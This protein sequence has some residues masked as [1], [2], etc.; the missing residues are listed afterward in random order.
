M[1]LETG[2]AV[3]EKKEEEADGEEEAYQ[4]K[5]EEAILCDDEGNVYADNTEKYPVRKFCYLLKCVAVYLAWAL[6]IVSNVFHIY[7]VATFLGPRIECYTCTKTKTIV[8]WF[9]W[10]TSWCLWLTTASFLAWQG[11][12]FATSTNNS[13]VGCVLF[14]LALPWS[15]TTAISYTFYIATTNGGSDMVDEDLCWTVSDSAI[16][17]TTTTTPT[18]AEIA[19]LVFDRIANFTAHYACMV[20]NLSLFVARNKTGKYECDR[21]SWCG[22]AAYSALG[23]IIAV[24]H[25]YVDDVYCTDNI[26]STIFQSIGV[27]AA[28]H[29]ALVLI[30]WRCFPRG[31]EQAD[32]TNNNEAVV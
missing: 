13:C 29:V 25:S 24:V 17:K 15:I 22:L 32:D 26:W 3:V 28:V 8:P 18:T 30:Q 20:I 10:F 16:P 23:I 7:S 19:F 27:F 9:I 6:L 21:M 31:D 4:P 5:E 11:S 12:I 14:R 1:E 2:S